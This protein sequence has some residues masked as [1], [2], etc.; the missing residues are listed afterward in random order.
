MKPRDEGNRDLHEECLQASGLVFQN[1]DDSVQKDKGDKTKWS[2]WDAVGK[3][4]AP[5]LRVEKSSVSWLL[6]S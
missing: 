4:H 1:G 5:V 3:E 6:L 2:S